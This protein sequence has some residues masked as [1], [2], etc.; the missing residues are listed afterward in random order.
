MWDVRCTVFPR[1]E[2]RNPSSN[3]R[4]I[5]HLT[6]AAFDKSNCYCG[7]ARCNSCP[8]GLMLH[9]ILKRSRFWAHEPKMLCSSR[10]EQM[11][12]NWLCHMVLHNIFMTSTS[13]GFL[14]TGTHYDMQQHGGKSNIKQAQTKK[15]KP[16]GFCS[17]IFSEIINIGLVYFYACPSHQES[18]V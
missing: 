5:V 1:C 13:D 4:V 16:L 18:H 15:K 10:F 8:H 3:G 17:V 2:N 14:W 12:R 6:S 11:D 9:E 7:S